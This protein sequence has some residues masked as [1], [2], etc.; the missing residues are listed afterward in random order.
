MKGITNVYTNFSTRKNSAANNIK[1]E[2][3]MMIYWFSES[4]E[5]IV[6]SYVD[7]SS[8]R[9]NCESVNRESAGTGDDA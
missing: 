3:M 2:G 5:T 6:D 1:R 7:T 9:L 8:A 4:V